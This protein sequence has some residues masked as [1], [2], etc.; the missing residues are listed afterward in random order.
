YSEASGFY[1]YYRG[2]IEHVLANSEIMIHYV[3]SDPNDA[4]L[5]NHHERLVPYYID[6]SRLIVLFMKLDADVAVMTTPDLQNYHLKRS[7]L[8]RDAEYIYMFHYPLSTHMVLPKGALDHYDTVFMVG[9]FQREEIRQWEKLNNL[10]E[11]KLVAVG[12]GVLEDMAVGYAGMDNSSFEKPKILIAPSW[13]D[14]NILDGPIDEVLRQL[15]G[16]GW[17]V[18]VRPHPEYVKRFG[19]AM[20]AVVERWQEYDGGDLFFELDFSKTNSLYDSDLVITDWSGSAYEFAFVTGKPALFINTPPK[21]NNPE[22]E[23]VSVAPLEVSLRERVGAS[24]DLDKLETLPEV[25]TGLLDAKVEYIAKNQALYEETIANV[26]ESARVGGG[27]LIDA[28][29][30][31]S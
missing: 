16:R 13:Q 12:Y 11:K 14:D 4:L 27:Y 20:A 29:N 22:Y 24:V 5:E 17:D 15:L 26:G 23:R 31:V 25:V 1:K 7:L 8:R 2:V 10:K 19:S 9:E 18:Y 21:V 30:K 6:D 28:V 3:T